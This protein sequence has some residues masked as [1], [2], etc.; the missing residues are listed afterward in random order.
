MT[1]RVFEITTKANRHMTG[2][3]QAGF[4]ASR[5]GNEHNEVS[6]GVSDRQS[7]TL[8]NALDTIAPVRRK[9][10]R[11]IRKDRELAVQVCA[12]EYLPVLR[13]IEENYPRDEVEREC[14]ALAARLSRG[15][16]MGSDPA[17]DR[18]FQKLLSR[19]E[20]IED[21]LAGDVLARTFERLD[22]WVA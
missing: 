12:R 21:V 18:T 1:M 20:V 3:R 11:A 16:E 17:V 22:R 6:V 5:S 15:L 9:L 2:V 10:H 19:Y 14:D 8:Q 4:F 13:Q 7:E